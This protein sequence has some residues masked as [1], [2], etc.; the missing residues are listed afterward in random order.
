MKIL[1]IRNT[2]SQGWVADVLW[3]EHSILPISIPL[4]ELDTHALSEYQKQV[5][6][7]T[8][9]GLPDAKLEAEHRDFM[10]EKQE[11]EWLIGNNCIFGSP[12]WFAGI[13]PIEF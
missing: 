6:A 11:Q 8:L 4:N 2:Q 13:E 3:S 9:N 5:D 7:E 12:E 10:S 1:D